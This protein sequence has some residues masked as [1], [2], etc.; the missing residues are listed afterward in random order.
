MS[1]HSYLFFLT[2]WV[3]G[4][5]R[6]EFLIALSCDWAN[7]ETCC[8]GENVRK[9]GSRNLI[10]QNRR[11]NLVGNTKHFNVPPTCPWYTGL[12]PW[13]CMNYSSIYFSGIVYLTTPLTLTLKLTSQF[14]DRLFTP[15]LSEAQIVSQDCITPGC[16][17]SR[18]SW[19]QARIFQANYKYHFF[20]IPS[21]D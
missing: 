19:V 15:L 12:Q 10:W 4:K 13:V 9:D 5:W 18:R 20:M 17:K 14:S 8:N 21:L 2:Y 11:Y 7:L 1:C 3:P 6:L 16:V